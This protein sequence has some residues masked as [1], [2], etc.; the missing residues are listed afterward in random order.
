L[1]FGIKLEIAMT[2]AMQNTTRGKY[3]IRLQITMQI[4]IIKIIN[5]VIITSCRDR[6]GM[7]T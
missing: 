5:G 4:T 6:A 1:V 2:I 3:T 7:N